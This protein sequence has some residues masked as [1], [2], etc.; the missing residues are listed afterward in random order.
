MDFDGY[1]L[2]LA[3][4]SVKEFHKSESRPSSGYQKTK[5]RHALISSG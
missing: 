5:S 2:F 3:S 4:L 1:F